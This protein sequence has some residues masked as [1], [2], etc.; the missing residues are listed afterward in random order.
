MTGQTR[1]LIKPAKP[2]NTSDP[3]G[4]GDAYRAGF[5][6]GYLR[7]FDLQTCGQMGS[8]AAVYTVEKYGTQTHEF[9]KEEFIKRY[10]DNYKQDVSL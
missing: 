2:A 1:M 9:T 6:A 5:L 7:K 4:A 8:V 3:T 10:K